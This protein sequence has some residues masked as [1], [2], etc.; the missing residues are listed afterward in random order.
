MTSRS[1]DMALQIVF[2]KL[3]I[4]NLY[5]LLDT[6]ECRH[7]EASTYQINLQFLHELQISKS[8]TIGIFFSKLI[9]N[10]SFKILQLKFN[11]NFYQ[12]F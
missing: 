3:I 7:D 12:F 10:S 6:I 4:Y 11:S 2:H 8:D 1:S 9:E 5:S